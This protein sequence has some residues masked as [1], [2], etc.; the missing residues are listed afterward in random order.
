MWWNNRFSSWMSCVMLS[1]PW[2]K[3]PED[4]FQDL[5]ESV[6]LKQLWRQRSTGKLQLTKRP[7]GVCCLRKFTR[8]GITALFSCLKKG[9]KKINKTNVCF[10]TFE[11]VIFSPQG[12]IRQHDIRALI[13]RHS[14]GTISSS[15]SNFTR[16]RTLRLCLCNFTKKHWL[17]QWGHCN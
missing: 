5:A 11:S 9:F 10:S 14:S 13:P 17:A 16:W 12:G 7:V 2:T 8:N 1:C 4:C 15:V 6:P 3:I